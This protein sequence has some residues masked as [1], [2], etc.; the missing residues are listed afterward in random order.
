MGLFTRKK[1]NEINSNNHELNKC[2]DSEKESDIELE[3]D[4][5]ILVEGFK[6]TTKDMICR[7][8]QYEINKK[9]TYEGKVEL[10]GSGYHFCKDLKKVFEYYSISN[11]N[12]FFKVKCLVSKKQWESDNDK[13]TAKEITFTEE[14]GYKEL[15]SFILKKYPY[16][17]NET[18]W[19]DINELGIEK[20]YKKYYMSIMLE[21]GYGE[22]FSNIL[23][24]DINNKIK[25]VEAER[26]KRYV[27]LNSYGGLHSMD[28]YLTKLQQS[29]YYNPPYDYSKFD[30]LIAKVKAFKEEG[31]SK[32]MAVYLLLK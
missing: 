24:D 2:N 23:Y 29:S 9:H 21:A 31:L 5:W 13:F 11:G 1:N 10:C 22:V 25:E 6:G 12:R 27:E 14:L 4:E 7:D 26:R 3:V 17:K 32:D 20:F 18:D 8:T 16:I 28:R 15:E 30:K 19:N